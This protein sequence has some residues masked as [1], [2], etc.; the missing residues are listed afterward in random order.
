M[1]DFGNTIWSNTYGGFNREIPAAIIPTLDGG[2]LLAC[3]MFLLPYWETCDACLFKT[4]GEGNLLWS[5]RYGGDH[6]D[7]ELSSIIQTNDG[8]FLAVGKVGVFVAGWV[9]LWLVKTSAEGD[10]LWS[11]TYGGSGGEWPATLLQIDNGNYLVGGSTTSFGGGYTDFW[12][13]CLEG[14]PAGIEPSSSSRL[15]NLFLY[16]PHPNPFNGETVLSFELPIASFVRLEVFD[17]NGRPVGAHGCAST[18]G[19]GSTP[20]LQWYPAGTHHITFDGRDLPSGIYLARLQAGELTSVQK[21]VLM[22]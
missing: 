12:M 13:L 17:V 10:S 7:E 2:Y 22:K 1:D 21:L 18:P 14:T 4:D 19:G 6:L 9:D 3:D 11:Q 8:D 5:K 16:H 15:P 20:A